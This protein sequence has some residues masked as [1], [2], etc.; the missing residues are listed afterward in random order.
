MFSSFLSQQVGL[1][2]EGPAWHGPGLAENL[3][4]IGAERAAS[5][6]LASA[7]SIW[8][9]VLHMTAWTREVARRLEGAE[10]GPPIDGDWPAVGPVSEQA[11]ARARASLAEAHAALAAA[12]KRFPEERWRDRVGGKR[13][14]PLGTGVSYGAMVAGLL[15]HD[16]Y[17]SGQV[18]LLRKALT[19]LNGGRP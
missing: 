4:G 18:G 13:D 19:E 9:L 2:H 10:P 8:E 17:H 7:H 6:P 15:Q 5:K 12:V 16:A 1:A 3:E 11:W 14:A